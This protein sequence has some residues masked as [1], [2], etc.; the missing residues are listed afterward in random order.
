[1]AKAVKRLPSVTRS[2]LLGDSGMLTGQGRYDDDRASELYNAVRYN[3]NDGM[4]VGYEGH[5]MV[6]TPAY[7]EEIAL[8]LSLDGCDIGD[9]P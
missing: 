9:L 6:R 2:L 7:C 3:N 1:M 5:V 4:S 8:S